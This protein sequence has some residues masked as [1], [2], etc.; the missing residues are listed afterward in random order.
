MIET[1]VRASAR[2]FT[3][4]VQGAAPWLFA[5][6]LLSRPNVVGAIWPSS[7][8]LARRMAA[9]VPKDGNGMVVELGGGTGVV[10]QALLDRG[11][12]AERL[13]VVERSAAFVRHLRARFP[14]VRVVLGNAAQLTHLL[15]YAP[16]L[17][18]IV[19]SLPLRSLPAADVAA[20]V[21]QWR[22]LLASGG[23][24]IQYTYDLRD[25]GRLGSHGFAVRSRNTVWANLPPARVLVFTCRQTRKPSQ[26]MNDERRDRIDV[27]SSS[28]SRSSVD[29]GSLRPRHGDTGKQARR[30]AG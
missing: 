2:R 10:T 30:F 15:P 17:D 27:P 19:S 11:I 24:A 29:A 9:H 8:Q 21:E 16:R 22:N 28:R 13:V 23:L 1:L 20:I 5:R 26:H 18:A 14:G 4:A 7:R 12:A 25:S 6:E 3:S